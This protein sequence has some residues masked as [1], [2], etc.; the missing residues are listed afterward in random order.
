MY[1]TYLI[2]TFYCNLHFHSAIFI[3][4]LVEREWR[5]QQEVFQC[6]H[7]VQASLRLQ[8]TSPYKKSRDISAPIPLSSMTLLVITS[9]GEIY[10]SIP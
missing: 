9:K 3:Y 2:C 4:N 5:E 7:K 1:N 10:F 8:S 6:Y